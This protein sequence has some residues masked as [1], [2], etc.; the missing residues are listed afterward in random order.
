[1]NGSWLGISPSEIVVNAPKIAAKTEM[2]LLATQCIWVADSSRYRSQPLL[3]FSQVPHQFLQ[4]FR[5]SVQLHARNQ[6]KVAALDCSAKAKNDEN[7]VC[8]V[9]IPNTGVNAVI[10]FRDSLH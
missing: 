4:S 6:S 3:Q 8:S 7:P 10:W 5:D 1:L 9:L 2:Y